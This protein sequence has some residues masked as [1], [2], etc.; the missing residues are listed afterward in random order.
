M[1]SILPS[2][3]ASRTPTAFRTASDSLATAS[4]IDSVASGKHH[5]RFHWPTFSNAARCS[6]CQSWIGVVRIGSSS[7]GPRSRPASTA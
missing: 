5:G 2:V 4:S 1:T 3:E 6:T 7:A